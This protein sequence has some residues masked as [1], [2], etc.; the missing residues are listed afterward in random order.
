MLNVDAP[1]G[2]L[3][4]A[5][6]WRILRLTLGLNI[7]LHGVTRL[8]SGVG[9]FASATVAQFSSTPLPA[10]LVR[11]FATT[12]PFLESAVG[13]AITVGLLTRLALAAGGLLMSAL[14]FGTALRS[15]WTTLGI[16]M[17]YAVVYFL[18]LA[19]RVD[20]RF[21]LDHLLRSRRAAQDRR[22]RAGGTAGRA[23]L[24]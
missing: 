21:G 7:L 24:G 9:T 2:E 12:L 23:A 14:V 5:L 18:L 1:G 4:R 16:Q 20:D 19:F 22:S 6:A 3:D 13:L 15:D 10:G 8:H 11:L 17:V